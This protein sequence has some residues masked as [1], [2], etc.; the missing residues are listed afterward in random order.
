MTGEGFRGEVKDLA[1]IMK[2]HEEYHTQ[3]ERQL[4]KS[5]VVK[6]EGSHL[7]QERNFMSEEVWLKLE[8]TLHNAFLY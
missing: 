1:Q 6:N 8:Q 3:I 4:D 7:I 5:E 2:R